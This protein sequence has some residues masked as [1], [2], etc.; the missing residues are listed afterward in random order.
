MAVT[1]D[2]NERKNI[3]VYS[4]VLAYFPDA[5][6]A[7]A[8]LS[9]KG[10]DKHNPGEPLHWARD[11]STDHADCLVRHQLEFDQIDEEDGEYH[12]V[13]VAWRALAQLQ[14]LLEGS[15]PPEKKKRKYRWILV[16]N[17]DTLEEGDLIRD[18]RHKDLVL[19]FSHLYD[20]GQYWAD[21]NGGE[22]GH[23]YPTEYSGWQVYTDRAAG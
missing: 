23:G 2:S 16:R 10:N 13:K 18:R 17:W 3:P 20:Q 6:V 14:T 21:M 19:G 1:S 9:R 4:G 15:P 5:L 22:N 8:R 12:A 11:K 7:V